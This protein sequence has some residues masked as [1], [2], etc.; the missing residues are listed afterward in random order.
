MD[1][2]PNDMDW[3]LDSMVEYLKSPLWTN[4]I[5]DFIDD[6]CVFFAGEV[7]DE[8]SL[9]H[10]E[11]HNRFKNLVDEKLDVFCAEFGINYELFIEA[12]SKVSSK[13]HRKCL[14]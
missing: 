6:N 1:S 5:C 12:A 7:N 9:D 4:D 2:Q 8:N 3:L 13:L 10:T 11:I 14:D